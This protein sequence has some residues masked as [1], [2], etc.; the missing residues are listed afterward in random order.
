MKTEIYIEYLNKNNGHAIDTIF[1]KSYEEAIVW[2][3]KN[4][5]NFNSDVIQIK[6]N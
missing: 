5:D 4:L 6:F 1:F 2:G 3:R